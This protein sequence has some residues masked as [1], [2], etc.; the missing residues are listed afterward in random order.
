MIVVCGE[1]LVDLVP[2]DN[3]V[4]PQAG[5]SA[6]IPQP[7]GSAA[8]VAVALGR[9]GVD[10]SLLTRLSEDRFGRLLRAHLAESRVD[11]SAAVSAKEHTTLAVVDLDDHGDAVY[12]FY[13]DGAGWSA[14]EFPSALAPGA[15]LHVSGS[16]AIALPAM[17][18]AIE[19]L[20][21][22]ERGQRVISFDPNPRPT[23]TADIPAARARL[24]AWLGLAD[25]VKVSAEDLAWAAPGES[26]EE[27]A[28]HWRERG[29]AL[30]VIT[31]GGDGVYALGPSGPCALPANPVVLVDTVGAGDSFMA[32]LVAALE[33]SGNLTPAGL[34]GLGRTE[35]ADSLRYAQRVAAITC[36]RPGADPPWQHELHPDPRPRLG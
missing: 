32:G 18:D 21:R 25:I 35:L 22:R 10:V 36:A 19:A 5:G 4:V 23:L 28:R 12:T 3:A 29:A 16:L 6:L 31:R 8:N 34:A 2:T 1:A 20:L 33:R 13:V 15:A 7:G 11:L 27:V 24:D 9:L 26:V 17:G 30:V 14:S